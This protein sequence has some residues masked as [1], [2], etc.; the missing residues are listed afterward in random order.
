[1]AIL[2][3]LGTAALA[4][5]IVTAGSLFLV[6]PDPPKDAAVQT[7]ALAELTLP[8][9][10]FIET[11]PALQDDVLLEVS[12]T[13]IWHGGLSL[14][15]RTRR[16]LRHTSHL[17]QTGPLAYDGLIPVAATVPGTHPCLSQLVATATSGALVD[18]T[19]DAPCQAQSLARVQMG[20]LSFDVTVPR[21][22]SKQIKI[23]ALTDSVDIKVT[24]QN[25][26]ELNANVRVPDLPLYDRVAMMVDGPSPF[27]LHA[28]EFGA[29]YAGDG[30]VWS[31]VPH[32]NTAIG[33]IHVLG[34]VLTGGK[35]AQVYSIASAM[36][37]KEGEVAITIEA[38]L[39]QATCGTSA[40][41]TALQ[42]TR[43]GSVDVDN[44][45]LD[46]PGCA[47]ADGYILLPGLVH[48]I[49]VEPI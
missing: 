22:G 3:L 45:A 36:A 42:T 4:T 14:R 30:H 49:L 15:K 8:Q 47:D 43:N 26:D 27:E 28:R 33:K 20:A 10:T 18:L 32:S 1:M 40:A 34:D 31:A 29:D 13:T 6:Q 38:A 44:I 46:L 21:S 7:V 25:S 39:T 16:V 24:F 35:T 12:P 9:P 5:C 17:I 41:V 19:I 48:D 37:A 2:K 11:L 23:P